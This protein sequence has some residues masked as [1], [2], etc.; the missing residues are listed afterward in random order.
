MTSSRRLG[1]LSGNFSGLGVARHEYEE[2]DQVLH[3]YDEVC[4]EPNLVEEAISPDRVISESA[5]NLSEYESNRDVEGLYG[6]SVFSGV[7]PPVGP[8]RYLRQLPAPS[9]QS[10]SLNPSPSMQ[11]GVVG[12]G[13]GRGDAG[14]V[15]S[16]RK[17]PMYERS[18]SSSVL[19]LGEREMPITRDRYSKSPKRDKALS[20]DEPSNLP[21]SGAPQPKDRVRSRNKNMLR[22]PVNN[23]L[24]AA[25]VVKPRIGR[26]ESIKIR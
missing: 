25:P 21:K 18:K 15:V 9:L 7:P 2:E 6:Y 26:S 24:I 4:F 13:H 16:G 10:V 22:L 23:H 11:H 20:L 5:P 8:P 12:T 1:G 19:F 17:P 14:S 3:V